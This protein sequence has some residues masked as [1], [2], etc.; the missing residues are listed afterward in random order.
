MILPNAQLQKRSRRQFEIK[1]NT[2][3]HTQMTMQVQLEAQVNF[4][5]VAFP[6]RIPTVLWGILDFYLVSF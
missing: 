3:L 5:I 6:Y 2:F 1:V 4:S